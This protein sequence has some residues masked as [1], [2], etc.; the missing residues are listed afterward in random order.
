MAFQLL[1][2]TL[3][4]TGQQ[5]LSTGRVSTVLASS[6]LSDVYVY[7]TAGVPAFL[8]L[9]DSSNERWPPDRAPGGQIVGDYNPQ[10]FG[11]ATFGPVVEVLPGAQA[12][13]PIAPFMDIGVLTN[14]FTWF[15]FSY[16]DFRLA[17]IVMF[18]FTLGF[19]STRMFLRRFLSARTYWIQA[20]FF[21]TIFLSTFVGKMST[22][23]FWVGILYVALAATCSKRSG[24]K[25]GSSG[26]SNRMSHV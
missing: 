24:A 25:T 11:A 12:W 1:G 5:A 8:K 16:R 3:G 10:T 22:S 18:G 7:A 14:V 17:G 2:T 26:A 20:A 23:I 19:V 4:K 6:G 21:S 9:V 13:N 15:E